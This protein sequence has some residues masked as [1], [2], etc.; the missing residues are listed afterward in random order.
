VDRVVPSELLRTALAETAYAFET[1]GPHRRQARE[2]LKKLRSMVTRFENHG[3]AT[4]ARVAGHLDRLAVGDES[5]AAI[6]AVDAVSLMTVHAA[7]GLEFPIVFVVNMN[8]GTGNV[9]APIRISPGTAGEPSVA[10][11]DYQSEADDDAAA[12][13]REETKRLLY[14]ALTRARD[15]LYLSATVRDGVC[16][17]TRGSLGEVL[18]PEMTKLFEAAAREG[19]GGVLAW[20]G[21]TGRVHRFLVPG[22]DQ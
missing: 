17:A 13:E 3:F 19:G 10:I 1:R 16:R 14:V 2:N 15:R 21:A 5:N 6:D 7:K 8:R 20:A 9:R 11:A 4:L 18:P 22:G 12:R